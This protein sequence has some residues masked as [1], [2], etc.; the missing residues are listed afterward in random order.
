MAEKIKPALLQFLTPGEAPFKILVVESLYYLPEIIQMLPKAE[1]YAVASEKDAMEKY[2]AIAYQVNFWQIDYRS[3]KLPFAKEIFDYIISDLTLEQTGNPQDIA[4][5]F[6]TYLKETGSFLTSFRNIRHWSQLKNLIDG[7][8]YNVVARLYAK[9]EFERLLYA[10]YYKMVYMLPQVNAALDDTVAKLQKFG[11]ENIHDDLNTEFW[12]VKADKSMPELSLLKSMYSKKERKELAKILH[13]IEYDVAAEA[14]C[15]RFW[16]L[17]QELGLF[18]DYIANFVKQ[19]VY[20]PKRFYE[21]L[22]KNSLAKLNNILQM[23]VAA[24]KLATTAN[25][26]A[27][28]MDLEQ[29]LQ[30]FA[31]RKA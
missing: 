31:G 5:G 2:A 27:E 1:V 24:Q 21:C 14:A 16:Q 3:E 23:V 28:L 7:H 15:Q 20:H 12:L 10:S 13:R 4:A 9:P 30:N 11:F 6:S 18:P 22:G 8:Y 17:W 25:E 29:K 19:A 26:L